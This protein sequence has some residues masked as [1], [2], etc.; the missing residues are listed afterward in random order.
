M[1]DWL[2]LF[3]NDPDRFFRTLESSIGSVE[4]RHQYDAMGPVTDSGDRAY[5]RFQVMGENV[6][7]WTERHFGTKLTPTEFLATPEAQHA[8]FRGEM[9]DY[10]SKYGTLEDAA[11]MWFSG[12]PFEG[13]TRSD[14]YNTVPQYVAKV[15]R[16]A[17][18]T[19]KFPESVPPMGN[20]TTGGGVGGI[21]E[22]MVGKVDPSDVPRSAPEPTF[23]GKLK[24]LAENDAFTDALGKVDAGQYAQGTGVDMMPGPGVGGMNLPPANEGA[25]NAVML[26]N[27][28]EKIRTLQ[29]GDDD[30]LMALLMMLSRQA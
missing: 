8:V 14:G 24:E 27:L 12:K 6:G 18:E 15:Q 10:F 1:F 2:S 17:K 4:S 5:G 21:F 11:S 16:A 9:G 26:Q 20:P 23:W 29:S 25:E 13:N 3:Q 30:G 19:L 22:E 7:P 28:F